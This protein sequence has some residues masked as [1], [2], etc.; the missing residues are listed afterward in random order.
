MKE[1]IKWYNK[2]I[3]EE[4]WQIAVSAEF[5]YRFLA[6][7]PFQD[8]NGRLGRALMLMSLLHCPN[9][10]ISEVIYY[11]AIDR[12]IEKHK[13]E[14]YIVLNQCSNGLYRD[15]PNE[16]NIEIF[17]KYMIKILQEAMA[18]IDFYAKRA[19]DFKKLPER[20]VKI[21]ECFKERAEEKIKT[22]DII[23]TTKFP[24]RT[25]TTNLKILT[26][27]KFVARYGQG[28]ATYYQL[29]F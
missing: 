14:Y 20:A 15:D 21:L 6:I 13:E 7:H 26:D 29:I 19:S 4:P 17:L 22:K 3:H 28:A 27:K 23:D 25:V 1:L 12:H 18:D 24:R 16:Y 11:L 8:G 5:V 10:K 9:K 2:A